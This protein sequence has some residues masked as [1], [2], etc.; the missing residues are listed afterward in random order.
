[1]SEF[2]GGR[3]FSQDHEFLKACEGLFDDI[4]Y[5][6]GTTR[7][8]HAPRRFAAKLSTPSHYDTKSVLFLTTSSD[9]QGQ[10]V[11]FQKELGGRQGYITKHSTIGLV[12]SMHRSS[13]DFCDSKSMPSSVLWTMNGGFFQT[14]PLSPTLNLESTIPLRSLT[15]NS[16][17]ETENK[18]E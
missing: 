18:Q 5:P 3:P 12:I 8:L 4:E 6:N 13:N 2:I 9:A 16:T 14:K 17:L 11:E 15:S 7:L 10:A 1:L